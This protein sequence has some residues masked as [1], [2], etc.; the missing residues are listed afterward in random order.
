MGDRY[1]NKDP[2]GLNDNAGAVERGRWYCMDCYVEMNTPGKNDDILRRWVDGML[3]YDRTNLKFRA[4]GYEDIKIKS[5]SHEV[6]YGGWPSPQD[7]ALFLNE[8]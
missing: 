3:A 7:Q 8:V 4:E 1:R 6:H 2:W 5:W